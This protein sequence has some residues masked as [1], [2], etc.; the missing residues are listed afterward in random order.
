MNITNNVLA[1]W[2]PLNGTTATGYILYNHGADIFVGGNL[3]V[4]GTI[5]HYG[6]I[7]AD[8]INGIIDNWAPATFNIGEVR[9]IKIS[10]NNLYLAGNLAT[11]SNSNCLLIKHNLVSGLSSFITGTP[12][13]SYPVSYTH[14]DVYKRQVLN[15]SVSPRKF[16][17]NFQPSVESL[18]S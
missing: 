5:N 11:T 2:N 14:L 1:N 16:S 17:A 18:K 9:D 13:G 3:S 4:Y 6:I 12:I 15:I 8:K 7:K 10:G